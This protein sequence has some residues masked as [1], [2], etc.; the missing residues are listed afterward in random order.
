MI[1][2]TFGKI[3]HREKWF[4]KPLG[5]SA[6]M[7]KSRD[8]VANPTLKNADD[9]L[10]KKNIKKIQLMILK[11]WDHWLKQASSRTDKAICIY[12]DVDK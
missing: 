5:K 4:W 12:I 10:Q 9:D 6:H 7:S 8:Q 1:M 2:K 3:W 11:S